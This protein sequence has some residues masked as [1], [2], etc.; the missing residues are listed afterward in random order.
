MRGGSREEKAVQIDLSLP[1]AP[2]FFFKSPPSQECSLRMSLVPL[3]RLPPS[4]HR[5]PDL[6]HSAITRIARN[7]LFYNLG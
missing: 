7:L 2:S 1:P 4:L 6:C 5:A 3:I